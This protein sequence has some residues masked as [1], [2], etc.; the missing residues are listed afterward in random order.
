VLVRR[1]QCPARPGGAS[2]GRRRAAPDHPREPCPVHPRHRA[3][4]GA[5]PRVG[6]E[7]GPGEGGRPPSAIADSC[8][9]WRSLRPAEAQFTDLTTVFVAALL[10]A[11]LLLTIL[12]ENLVFTAA[13][14]L[15]VLLSAM[16]VLGG[17]WLTGTE[18]DISAL[19]AILTLAP[20][21]LD[22]SR[23]G[24]AASSRGRDHQRPG[25]RRA[26]DRHAAPGL[27]PV[28]DET[29]SS[30]ATSAG[31]DVPVSKQCLESETENKQV[32]VSPG[33]ATFSGRK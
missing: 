2:L 16:V 20:L 4:R 25:H 8:R 26:F 14:T 11:A 6:G 5:R 30:A 28:D 21:A 31:S 12:F 15:T 18:L 9:I 7:G 3:A 27:N 33:N 22:W 13:V 29:R 1:A 32:D 10:L 23:H 17:L 24:A 19:I